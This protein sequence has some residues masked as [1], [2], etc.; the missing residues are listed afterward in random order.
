VRRGTRRP[1][2]LLGAAIL[3]GLAALALAAPF[4]APYP[5][6]RQDL[7]RRLELPSLE[8]PLGRDDLGRDILSRTIWGTRISLVTGLLVVLISGSVGVLAGAS[9]AYAGGRTDA[10]M[11]GLVDVLLSFP[12]I[13]LAIA[14]VAILGPKLRHL[15]LALCVVG[16]VAYARLARSLVRKL[17]GMDFIEAARALGGLPGG[18]V[19][20]HLLLNL[21]GPVMVQAALGLGGAILAEAGLSFLGLGVPPPAPSWG[22]MLR[23]GSQNLLDAP[24]LAIVPGG[25][26]FLAVLGANL[27]A[28]GLGRLLDPRGEA[29]GTPF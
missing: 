9:A 11:V 18:V 24:H 28:D 2:P 15:I 7:A 14:L 20:R 21:V 4:I 22:S 26:I 25:A 5:P 6:E 16:W 1:A 29:A 12:G 27:L 3:L 10:A 13:L 23:S 8:H 19:L 17:K